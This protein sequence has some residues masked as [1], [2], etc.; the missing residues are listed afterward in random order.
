VEFLFSEVAERLV[1]E[2]FACIRLMCQWTGGRLCI[3]NGFLGVLLAD[4][5]RRYSRWRR[6]P[7]H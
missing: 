5:R 4:K 6:I 3:D 2:D 7:G 1:S